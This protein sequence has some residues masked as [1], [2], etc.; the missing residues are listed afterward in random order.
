MSDKN[1]EREIQ[2]VPAWMLLIAVVVVVGFLSLVWFKEAGS[3]IANWI[4]TALVFAILGVARFS[5]RMAADNER[6]AIFFLGKFWIV[7]GPGSY[8]ALPFIYSVVTVNL[9]KHI[10]DWRKLHER[11]IT[12]RVAE[13]AIGAYNGEK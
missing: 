2:R 13:L 12:R 9:D 7:K 10:P 1:Q 3:D 11:D 8:L 5:L 6:A 4:W